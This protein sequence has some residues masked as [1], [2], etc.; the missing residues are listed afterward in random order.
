MTGY[1]KKFDEAEYVS[2]LI[3]NDEMLEKY[4]EVL[5]KVSNSIKKGFNSEQ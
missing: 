2:F 5:E 4:T 1:G 3:K